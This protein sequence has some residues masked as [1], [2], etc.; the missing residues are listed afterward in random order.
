M[1]VIDV[2]GLTKTFR[3]YRKQPGL[4]GAVRGR[5]VLCLAAGGG[6][7]GPLLA[8]A[9]ADVT[10]VDLSPAMLEV[11]RRVAASRGLTLSIAF[12]RRA[13]ANGTTLTTRTTATLS[14]SAHS[15][16]TLYRYCFTTLTKGCT[17]SSSSPS[18]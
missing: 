14:W 10:V 7:H 2:R 6:R 15:G 9:G 18:T 5:R 11:D 1:P 3:T 8:A 17:P 16:A 13:P 12:G 4:G